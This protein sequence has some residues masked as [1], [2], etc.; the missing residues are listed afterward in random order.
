MAR[1]HGRMAIEAARVG[2][3]AAA[4]LLVSLAASGTPRTQAPMNE[5]RCKALMEIVGGITME[6]AGQIS[7]DFIGDLQR[8]IG[9]EGKC[10]GPDEYRIWPNTRDREA[11]GRIRQL[12]T[13]WD[14]CN[15]EPAR[16]ECKQ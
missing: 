15:K 12:L 8:K 14:I 7:T 5:D 6:F 2:G 1:V 16:E 10:D 9:M 3:I 4:A 13:A 11:P